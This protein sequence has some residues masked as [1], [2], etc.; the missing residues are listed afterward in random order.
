MNRPILVCALLLMAAAALGAQEASQS[1]PYQGTSTPP[2]DD[3]IVTTRTPQAKPPAGQPAAACRSS[4]LRIRRRRQAPEPPQPILPRTTPTPDGGI[5]A[6][7]QSAPA[8]SQPVLTQREYDADPDG[9]IVH[10]HPLRPGE[11]PEGDHHS[12]RAAG[13]A[14]HHR[15]REGRSLPQ[16]RGL[17]M[18]CRAARC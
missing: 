10:P 16:P 11:L 3:T 13:S 5:V 6:V 18:C 4:L 14:L 12:R 15:Q 1:S 2:P 8:P 9:D 17:A 7:A